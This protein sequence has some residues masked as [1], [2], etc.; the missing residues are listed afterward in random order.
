[1]FSFKEVKLYL[2]NVLHNRIFYVILTTRYYVVFKVRWRM[3]CKAKKERDLR[4]YLF[5]GDYIILCGIF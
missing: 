1:M 3:K 2:Y 5:K 4:S